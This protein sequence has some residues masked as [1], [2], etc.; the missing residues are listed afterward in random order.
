MYNK[1]LHLTGR[2]PPFFS[3][4]IGSWAMGK[5]VVWSGS[6]L[7]T[8]SMGAILICCCCNCCPCCCCCCCCCCC[9]SCCCCSNCCCC[10]WSSVS[11]GKQNNFHS[12]NT[13]LLTCCEG[14]L[15]QTSSTALG[16]NTTLRSSRTKCTFI[17]TDSLALPFQPPLEAFLNSYSV[18][19]MF[20]DY[21]YYVIIEIKKNTEIII[22][23]KA[24][25]KF[26]MLCRGFSSKSSAMH[27][28]FMPHFHQHKSRTSIMITWHHISGPG[29]T[30]SPGNTK[31]IVQFNP[32]WFFIRI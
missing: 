25:N 20:W 3:W 9:S 23:P 29:I 28:S 7:M 6:V 13:K 15:V 26:R 19:S 14:K 21:E 12:R 17:L 1:D 18:H 16:E 8:Y 22:K 31:G 2:S 4:I 32:I 10:L 30:L 24:K 11:S 27:S 5:A